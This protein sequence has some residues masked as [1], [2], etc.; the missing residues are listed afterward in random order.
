MDKVNWFLGHDEEIDSKLKA[1]LETRDDVE[2]H[3]L[4]PIEC[5]NGVGRS[6]FNN[7]HKFL[8]LD[9][10]LFFECPQSFWVS[11]WGPKFAKYWVNS[12]GVFTNKNNFAHQFFDARDREYFI[13]PNGGFKTFPSGVY[14]LQDIPGVIQDCPYS[15]WI[16]VARKK[17][18]LT[19]FRFLAV[20]PKIITGCCYSNPSGVAYKPEEIE[21]KTQEILT[22]CY[23]YDYAFDNTP[24]IIDYCLT[25]GEFGTPN[26][27]VLELNSFGFSSLYDMNLEA[28]VDSVNECY[29]YA[30]EGWHK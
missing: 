26:L 16:Y 15:E 7:Y 19:E 21:N 28:V 18:I 3:G 2:V 20:G 29:R 12:G 30:V 27:K 6:T 4:P 25:P 1:Y 17:T 5:Y 8:G 10:G 22:E 9:P 23:V 14:R 11:D 24:Y 13:R